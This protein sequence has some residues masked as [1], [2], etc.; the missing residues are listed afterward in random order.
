MRD[1]VNRDVT[2]SHVSNSCRL[3]YDDDD[4]DDGFSCR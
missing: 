2:G 3:C 4:D 1:G